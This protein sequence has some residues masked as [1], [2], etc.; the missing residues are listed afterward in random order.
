MKF[1]QTI[2]FIFL[3]S[4]LSCSNSKP[5]KDRLKSPNSI[6]VL[7][8]TQY[9]N[10]NEELSMRLQFKERYA[11]EVNT[12]LYYPWSVDINS[13]IFRFRSVEYKILKDDL[14]VIYLQ[15]PNTGIELR[16][17]KEPSNSD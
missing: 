9:G 4:V 7:K 3:L 1:W 17:V 15:N 5:I 10:S 13:G 8:S 2:N 14:N 12:I 11:F 6:W 16:L